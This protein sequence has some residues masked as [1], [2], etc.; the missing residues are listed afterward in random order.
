MNSD[1]EK[2]RDKIQKSLLKKALGY[3][4]KEVIKEYSVDDNGEKLSKKKVTTKD[5]PPDLSAVKLF[6]DDINFSN[7]TNLEELSDEELK[8]EISNAMKMLEEA[9][10]GFVVSQ[11]PPNTL[12]KKE[13]KNA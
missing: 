4:Y 1:F 12:R 11:S 6:L 13:K 10:N 8:I 5:V 3:Q 7:E 2:Y 9:S